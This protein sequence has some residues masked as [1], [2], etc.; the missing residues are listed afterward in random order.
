MRELNL[1]TV[2]LVVP[3]L[4]PFNYPSPV[5]LPVENSNVDWGVGGHPSPL[6]Q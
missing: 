2:F 5:C 3:P 1:Y 6:A 4:P